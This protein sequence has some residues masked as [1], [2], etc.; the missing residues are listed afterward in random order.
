MMKFLLKNLVNVRALAWRAVLAVSLL[1][2]A[3]EDVSAVNTNSPANSGPR[4]PSTF[5]GPGRPGPGGEGVHFAYTNSRTNEFGR[6][7]YLPRDRSRTTT[8]L[9]HVLVNGIPGTS[10]T[11]SIRGPGSVAF[12]SSLG[13][14]QGGS[15]LALPGIDY[16]RYNTSPFG[17]T[18]APGDPFGT[19][20]SIPS[21]GQDRC[22]IILVD[23]NHA[24]FNED[25]LL[26]IISG[27]PAAI[28][29][30]TF[31]IEHD[32]EPGGAAD[33]EFS[34]DPP[35]DD[36]NPNPGANG[37]V[38]VIQEVFHVADT[39]QTTRQ[40]LIG[41]DFTAVNRV[42]VNRITRLN[43]DGSL[44]PSFTVGTG[45]D[46]FV[47]DISVQP[48][49]K[50]VI[51]GGFTSVNGFSREGVARL[52][53]NG[54]VD[55]T[56][57]P[58]AGIAGQVRSVTVITNGPN[59][60][61][62]VVA[63][64]FNSANSTNRNHIARLNSDGKLDPTFDT[65][66]GPNGPVFAAAVQLDGK[67]VV[68]GDFTSINGVARNRIARLNSNGSLD[69]S[70][71]PGAGID[72]KVYDLDLV[73]IGGAV[74]LSNTAGGTAAEQRD[75]IDTGA[76]AG[77]II[78]NYDFLSQP[79]QL[80]VYYEGNRIFDTGLTNGIA[81]VQIGYGPG[82]ST[83]IEIVV[84][85]GGSLLPTAW[86]YD[87][88]IIPVQGV[89]KILVGGAFNNVD[90]RSRNGVVRLNTDGSLD[91]TF[92]PGIGADDTVFSVAQQ[93]DGKFIIG[94]LF[95]SYNE[96]AR[97]NLARLFS[98]GALDTS[99]MDSAYNQR[100]GPTNN[101][102]II[103]SHINDL[104]IQTDGHVLLGGAFT[105][106]GGSHGRLGSGLQVG[107]REFIGTAI[108]N[109][110]PQT[111]VNS[112]F[113][114]VDL[115]YGGVSSTN[116][117]G[118]ITNIAFTSF[119][120]E[121]QCGGTGGTR[122]GT[123]NRNNFA[124][125]IGGLTPTH[126]MSGGGINGNDEVGG[127]GNIGFTRLTYGEDENGTN[128]IV[129]VT[130]S[131]GR[132]GT[133]SAI[134]TTRDET[135]QAGADYAGTV[136]IR[137]WISRFGF[138]GVLMFSSSD[139]TNKI[140]EIPILD[141]AIVEGDETLS[142]AF[143]NPVGGQLLPESNDFPP[144][145]TPDTNGNF[146]PSYQATNIAIGMAKAFNGEATLTILDDDFDFGIFDFS[147]TN[148][149]VGEGA[150]E[151]VV[152]VTR[153]GGSVG[154][155]SVQYSTLAGGN[156]VSPI[157]FLAVTNTLSFAPGETQR[158]FRVPIVNDTLLEFDE[159]V[160]LTLSN[161]NGGGT[162]GS[163][164]FATLT[165]LDDDFGR[166]TISLSTNTYNIAES[167][168]TA[169][170][171][172]KRTSGSTGTV[173]VDLR[174]VDSSAVDGVDYQG[175][176]TN[177]SF[178]DGVMERTVD[179]PIL[180]DLLVN[181]DVNLRLELLSPTGGAR[182]GVD[183]TASLEIANDDF[184]GALQ[185]ASVDYFTG[186]NSGVTNLVA[187]NIAII[188]VVRVNGSAGMVSAQISIGNASI[189]SASSGTDYVGSPST[190]VVL[191]PGETQKTFIVQLVDDSDIEA[192]ET[193]TLT[194]FGQVNASLGTPSTATL[195]IIDDES[196][197]RPAGSDDT[198][199]DPG[200]GADNFVFATAIQPNRKIL[201]GGAFNSVNGTSRS[202]LARLNLSGDVDTEFRP[203]TGAD[204]VVN[205]IALQPNGHSLFGG[206]FRT[207][208]STNVGGI[209]RV[210]PDASVD[211]TFNP[212]AG[213]DN[214]ILDM[215]LNTNGSIV[216]VG[217]FS[218]YNGVIRNRIALVNTNGSLNTA[219][220]PGTGADN[221]VR[222][223]ALYTNG[224]H[225]SKVVV[226][227]DF[228]EMNGVVANRVSRLNLADGSVDAAFTANLGSAVTNGSVHAVALQPLDGKILIGGAFAFVDGVSRFGIARL[229]ADGSL[230]TT[231]DPGIGFNNAVFDIAI[232][233]DGKIIAV[234][235]FTSY[236]GIGANRIVRINTDG[237]I[238][239]TINFG[240]GANNFISSVSLQADEK[241]VI[242]GGFTSYNGIPR[243]YIVRIVGGTNPGSGQLEFAA[244][245][246]T[247][248][249]DDRAALITVSR[250]RG[251][252]DK[253]RVDAT[254]KGGTAI[255][256]LNYVT[257]LSS[258]TQLDFEIGQ[259][260]AS[261]EILLNDD[262]LTDGDKT[263]TLQ[264][265]SP[266]HVS[267]NT[268]APAILGARTNAT[269]TILDDDSIVAFAASSF[270]VSEGGG[271][272]LI[273]VER[274]GGAIG[275][276]TVRFATSNNTAVAGLDF[277]GVTNTLAFAAGETRKTF[278]I[279]IIDDILVEGD[280]T[281]TLLLF[282][283]QGA[284][285][286]G[287][288]EVPLRIVDNDLRPGVVNFS[289]SKYSIDENAGNATVSVIRTNGTTGTVTVNYMTQDGLAMAGSDYTATS[290]V[291][292]FPDG[293]T[294][295]LFDVFV[296]PDFDSAETNESLVLLLSNPQG[297]AILGG[298]NTATLS[299]QNNN[300][301][302]FG[303]M[304]FSSPTFMVAEGVGIA[305]I[306]VSRLTGSTGEVTVDVVSSNGTAFAD[307]D[308][309]GVTNTLTFA[310]GVVSQTV[311]IPIIN[312]TPALA[313]G[314]ETVILTLLN[315][316]GGAS[317][318][319]QNTAELTIT[320]DDFL[321]GNFSFSSAQIDVN[322][323]FTNAV[324]TVLRTNGSTGV[325]TVD[326]A[327]AP[328]TATAGED[329]VNTNGTLTFGIGVTTNTFEVPIISNPAQEGHFTVLLSLSNPGGGAS[330]SQVSSILRIIDNEPAAG[331]V[332]A[333]FI[334]FSGANEIIYSVAK[335]DQD[336]KLIIAGDFT[337]FD[338]QVRSNVA[339]LNLDGTLDGSF[340]ASSISHQG[341]NATVRSV[342]VVTNGVNI[343]KVLIGGRFDSVGGTNRA[344]VAR[345]NVDGSPDVTFDPG[346]G[347]N[348]FV[349]AL[350]AQNDGRV[351]IGGEFTG[352]N[353]V[354]RN[355]IARLNDDG[356]VDESFNP[357]FG[358]NDVVRSISVDINGF[359][360][361]GG[362]FTSFDSVL[363]RGVVRL[364]TD[365][366]V[367]KT[368]DAGLGANGPV[369]SVQV[370]GNN[371]SIVLGGEF[372]SMNGDTN[373]VRIARLNAD[374]TVDAGFQPN[375]G[376]N[377]IVH[378]V[379]LQSDG[380][381]I[382][383][384][385]F[386]SIG[387]ITN[388]N[389]F[390][391]LEASGA[392]DP[393]FNIGSGANRFVASSLVQS[394]GKVVIA[395]DFTLVNGTTQNRIARL[396][397]GA[398]I[399][400]GNLSFLASDFV[401]DENGITAV[402]SVVRT[403]AAGGTISVD[404]MTRDGSAIEGVNYTNTTG[405]LTF[406]QSESIKSF[407]VPI[408]DNTN[409]FG[410][411]TIN[412]SIF[413]ASNVTMN[414]RNDNVLVT[415]TNA[416]L[417][418][419]DNDG[420][421]GFQSA[422]FSVA[423][424]DTNATITVIRAG[425]ATESLT[426][427]F[428]VA[429]GTAN[430]IVDYT[431]TNGT[432]FFTNGQTSATFDIPIFN[433]TKVEGP[434]TLNLSLSNLLGNAFLSQSMSVLR[435]ID[436]EFSP[437]FV[438]FDSISF[439]TNENAPA[440]DIVIRRTHGA[441]GIVTVDYATSNGTATAG[442]DYAPQSD[443]VTFADGEILRTVR[444][445]L[446]DDLLLEG[447]ETVN[448]LLSNP[449]GNALLNGFGPFG[450]LDTN[451]NFGF[452]PIVGQFR[453]PN[454]VI[455][456]T[457]VQADGRV[458]VAGAFS[459]W[460]DSSGVIPVTDVVR[461]LPSGDLDL[462][463]NLGTGVNNGT[464]FEVLVQP[465]QNIVLA[466]TFTL[467]DTN[468]HNRIVRLLPSGQVD[469]NFMG[470]VRANNAIFSVDIRSDNRLV[471]AG[472]FTQYGGVAANRVALLNTDG[473]LNAGFNPGA[474]PNGTVDEVIVQPNDN[475]VLIGG[476]FNSF[477]GTNN[478]NFYARLLANGRLD[479]NFH[480]ASGTGANFP[481]TAIA[482]Q[483][484]GRILI[485]GDFTSVGA[486]NSTSAI[487]GIA[488]LLVDGS[489][490]TSFDPGI[491]AESA[492]LLPAAVEDIVV[493][494]FDQKI[495]VGGTF[496][497]FNGVARNRIERLNP[498]GSRDTSFEPCSG[499][500]GSFPGINFGNID[501]SLQA[502]GQIIVGGNFTMF[503]GETILGLARLQPG[504][505]IG[506][507]MS[508][509][510]IVDN[511]VELGFSA[512]QFSVNES[513]TNITVQI[514]RTGLT[515]QVFDVLYRTQD[516]ANQATAANA[517]FDYTDT[518]GVVTFLAGETNKTF[519]VPIFNDADIEGDEELNLI[520]ESPSGASFVGF[521]NATLTI[522]DD[523]VSSDLIILKTA[524]PDPIYKGATFTYFLTVSN[525]GPATL[526]G[527]SIVDTLPSQV[528]L[529][530]TTPNADT[531]N[532][533]FV[534]FDLGKL[535]AGGTNSV[536]ITVTAPNTAAAIVNSAS[537]TALE[538][539]NGSAIDPN[540]ANNTTTITTQI[541]ND[542][543]FIA[544]AG[545][546]VVSESL[547]PANGAID[548]TETVTLTLSLRNLGN[549]DTVGDI[550]AT[551]LPTSTITPGSPLSQNYG[552]MSM[553]SEIIGRDFQFTAN[554]TNGQLINVMLQVVDNNGSVPNNIVSFPFLLGG[555]ASGT[556]NSFILIQEEGPAL[557][558]PSS[559]SITGATGFVSKVSLT[560]SNY[561]HSFPDD[562]D[563]LLVGPNGQGVV[564]LSDVG[565]GVDVNGLTLTIDD[566]AATAL[567]NASPLVAG[568]FQPANYITRDETP[569]LFPT[570]APSGPYAS[571]LTAF[572][573]SDPNGVWSLYVV[574]DSRLDSGSIAGGWS[575]DITTVFAVDPTANLALSVSDAPDPIQVGSNLTY[576]L[577]VT[578][579]GPTAASSVTI[580]DTLP[581]GATFVSA[582]SN[583]GGTN[584][585]T[586]SQVTFTVGALPVGA[587]ATNTVMMVP[588]LA[589]IA[590]NSATVSATQ[591]DPSPENNSV[592][593]LTTVTAVAD[594]SVVGSTNSVPSG[595]NLVYTFTV[596]N[597]GPLTAPGVVLEGTLP[598]GIVAFDASSSRGSATV[599]SASRVTA[600][601]GTLASNASA[602][603]TIVT[604]PNT[605]EGTLV[606]TATVSSLI[607]DPNL[608]NNTAAASSITVN[609]S[610]DVAI[611]LINTPTTVIEGNNVTYTIEVINNG[612]SIA[613]NVVVTNAITVGAFLPASSSPSIVFANGVA[614]A[615]LGSLAAGANVVLTVAVAVPTVP[616]LLPPFNNVVG[617]RTSTPE[618]NLANNTASV[619]TT[620]LDVADIAP[621]SATLF[622][623]SIAP[624]NSAVD[625]GETVTVAF[626]L[627]NISGIATANVIAT[628]QES[629]GV[630]APT[631]IALVTNIVNGVTNIVETP[632]GDGK[633]A[634]GQLN[635][636]EDPVSHKFRF[637]AS[638]NRGDIITATLE[639]EDGGAS[640]GVVAFMFRLGEDSR[641][642]S[643]TE[644]N[645]PGDQSLP[646]NKGPAGPYPSTNVVSGLAGSIVKATV[647][648]S[649]LTHSFPDDLNILLVGPT[650]VSAILMSDVG[651]GLGLTNVTLTFDDE[652]SSSLP[653]NHSPQILSGSYRP[654]DANDPNERA[655]VDF[656]PLPA[657][658]G[659]YGSALTNFAGTAPNGVW[660]LYI[661]DDQGFDHGNIADGWSLQLT[662]LVEVNSVV[663]MSFGQNGAGMA[664]GNPLEINVAGRV[665]MTYVIEVSGDLQNWTPIMTNKTF[666]GAVSFQDQGAPGAPKRFYRATEQ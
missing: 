434:E 230:D 516:G 393:T 168:G 581:A 52:E 502:D 316:S 475:R 634:Y 38:H 23:D 602:T 415:P 43:N 571:Q 456:D 39:N 224:V 606:A 64:D 31:T 577:T 469:T 213:V 530:S 284:T 567:P 203:G 219:F 301:F 550:V 309:T 132:L 397:S 165:I 657:P 551:L 185:F 589:G 441:S 432:L 403:R 440:A 277:V 190:V 178:G 214:P 109:T 72:D 79:D 159:D 339:R 660:S 604:E 305:N 324:I 201:L 298:Q 506:L 51:G 661:V 65:G 153:N 37:P 461:L 375:G 380:K 384:G 141:D 44:D 199:F 337:L 603:V 465:D 426:V 542:Q 101:S 70:F 632:T 186:E 228:V 623:E 117:V 367:D 197:N 473:T 617:V 613:N 388:I 223:A 164:T 268:N 487:N 472:S 549:Q 616:G 647:T 75:L 239:P 113:A 42:P 66:S 575:L 171:A 275:P 640:I 446:V 289:A 248:N 140:F 2:W 261:F 323:T 25:L 498:N 369:F 276:A 208:N 56:F 234:G 263:I 395:G 91:T 635:K 342:S 593:T 291:L 67:V 360:I 333:G 586:G 100:A 123:R 605:V 92:N 588:N 115:I 601:L 205:A 311:S 478:V 402:V 270:S 652:A 379:S 457:E 366:S 98:N 610:T 569:D 4:A 368:F 490:D 423:E 290:G 325:V 241:L 464:V 242:G 495:L 236:N 302:I 570:P 60:G 528:T 396:N 529:I 644:I 608:T 238:D 196:L 371:G 258:S 416:L 198:G 458:I 83:E 443:S 417:T 425:G 359:L 93:D 419:R 385:G 620:A 365:G 522:I 651:G 206:A 449:T 557:P 249:E 621:F 509:L 315:P 271:T 537:T 400:I 524:T 507:A 155:V 327:T 1:G 394:D 412:L 493:Q 174:T 584:S 221:R 435:I 370:A 128:A 158:V 447:D 15:D 655:P 225:S 424:D 642:V 253:V 278:G 179:I 255:P 646:S 102:P 470:G 450:T 625:P 264:L 467:F 649:N 546:S 18:E 615:N 501:F 338:G 194:L 220:N 167:G 545:A 313:E 281:V 269:L 468:S 477:D 90:F 193:V 398:N 526:N 150:G 354:L 576:T 409:P 607:T 572:N 376:P 262:R 582:T 163:R 235:D 503:S 49:G 510:T 452:D 121:A 455:F 267:G 170:V 308:Y 154:N 260:S 345:L 273:D 11:M 476:F 410:D 514:T 104:D 7:I 659:A 28:D 86:S 564:V 594:L 122:W 76:N 119:A 251:V 662:S 33:I 114:P 218:S 485:G 494:P 534:S 169:T 618:S 322:E 444:I 136:D 392:L 317:L 148:Y 250:S 227:G 454:G 364:R 138:E 628:L 97:T 88:T 3:A 540:L 638:G 192:E 344:N 653:D 350:V 24:E 555:G 175:V 130:R 559:I 231:F 489:V 558:Y 445:P 627:Q 95:T 96:T 480:A 131:N 413:N 622:S 319:L 243:N 356:S 599:I 279:P 217:E 209:V 453:G 187:T 578:N 202:K 30:A 172:L 482:L 352:V 656:F 411:T 17:L 162:L 310:D 321:A 405:T 448:L 418:I 565:G 521:T 120:R 78:I 74:Q 47:D 29:F 544:S 483:A 184:F 428:S 351:V 421:V 108:G 326:F 46:G 459:T 181:A 27:M 127:P 499:F 144:F 314:D 57:D 422:F 648:I 539:Q 54:V 191:G 645:I 633:G 438:E 229:N 147:V 107:G 329:F 414:V 14:I 195:T 125:V 497:S 295:Q 252:A 272:A 55:A 554:G 45:A 71:D 282:T 381:I 442:F 304:A 518:S 519:D 585:V 257:N 222:A 532:P 336:G 180:D 492:Q 82:A 631:A 274:L 611:T 491:G 312:E 600:T 334:P 20:R 429:D 166:G 99:F 10:Y 641:F 61:K 112:V 373:Y 105:A 87:V 306:T 50:I 508:S 212:G 176:F 16:L 598:P 481:V 85:E 479:T 382:I 292:T 294:N 389:R 658:V 287:V 73:N 36:S 663:V 237:S 296:L 406:G 563:M 666:N 215:A 579:L 6:T 69:L 256:G 340:D 420:V 111:L 357:G 541:R 58:G 41:G 560:L 26:R 232:Q 134:L 361:V 511:D 486:T 552:P 293:V 362:D 188:N 556:N 460:T 244:L 355:H 517:G 643:L 374:G 303:E 19:V 118:G 430:A 331:D 216:I 349:H 496:S 523:D 53:T 177:I 515:N 639:L 573:G 543:P 391:R 328:G 568:V 280:E 629:G 536:S 595:T 353:G 387:A 152:T 157:D 504:L 8:N 590:S 161:P 189:D 343:G 484:N 408:V 580:I 597:R 574:D 299:I 372:T 59:T 266:F 466:G 35:F 377:E 346:T 358:A 626:A 614:T 474:G 265:S 233:P 48:D 135:G 433:D 103:R 548:P 300:G 32:D 630:T 240:S 22:P 143:N 40:V 62:I 129:E 637:T 139:L 664:Q 142:L 399:G 137:T 156:A 386:T 13:L 245:N 151:A 583:P 12:H 451:Y 404:Y 68:G 471:I 254:I 512:N 146:F 378:T 297:G 126:A 654:T 110:W 562:V 525:A 204:D 283:P 619:T 286:L 363:A 383:G 89:E 124:R 538:F 535:P 591:P 437:G 116:I 145:F 160:H 133:G 200:D 596:S 561:S 21:G 226:V 407:L 462:T 320:D 9:I 650:G 520:V 318:A 5:Y 80:R 612:P 636:G 94:G 341:S 436:D 106:M 332:D 81:I 439:T 285:V 533:A 84:N 592:T 427:D 149:F 182:L 330:I 210:K 513:A 609:A 547:S 307:F 207:Y 531:S 288:S 183:S 77:T 347:P 527:V 505:A 63:G 247:A 259:T 348:N 401:V 553:A 431:G 587:V 173:A 34:K 211:G 566:Q 665:G 500:A 246:F 463:F 624:A 488:R 390:A 335:F